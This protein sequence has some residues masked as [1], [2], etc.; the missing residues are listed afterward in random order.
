[1]SV[2]VSKRVFSS[3]VVVICLAVLATVL[4]ARALASDDT[5]CDECTVGSVPAVSGSHDLTYNE[6]FTYSNYGDLEIYDYRADEDLTSCEDDQS[7][8]DLVYYSCD[9]FD[10]P[11]TARCHLLDGY[12]P[13]TAYCDAE[14]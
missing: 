2:P 4:A 9:A 14:Y 6:M 1:M 10:P 3:A 11:A 5:Y 8:T 12:G 13:W 7:D